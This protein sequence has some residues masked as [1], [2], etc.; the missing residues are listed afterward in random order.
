MSVAVIAKNQMAEALSLTELSAPDQEIPASLQVTLTLF[1]F[2]WEIQESS[3]LRNYVDTNQVIIN[4][5]GSDL[6]KEQ[7][8]A[9]FKSSSL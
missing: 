8:L 2:V 5:D 3:E 9:F 1:N 7:S 6:T 4:L